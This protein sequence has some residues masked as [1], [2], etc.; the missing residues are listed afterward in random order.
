MGIK[1]TKDSLY[2]RIRHVSEVWLPVHHLKQNI[3]DYPPSTRWYL[4][5]SGQQMAVDASVH[6]MVNACRFPIIDFN[7]FRRYSSHKPRD[8]ER[9]ACRLKQ[10]SEL[11]PVM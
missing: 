1:Y 11:P 3:R 10:T 2:S 4:M 5:I 6:V 7:V 9:L 8:R